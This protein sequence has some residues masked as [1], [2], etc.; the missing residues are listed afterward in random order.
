MKYSTRIKSSVLKKILPPENRSVPS[1][2]K[3]MGI[4]DQTIYNWKK[5]AANG[6]LELDAE[7]I[8][9][10]SLSSIEKFILL[11]E[12]KSKT[13]EIAGVWLREKGL[14]SEHLNLWEQELQDMLKSKDSKYKEEN[15]RLK[16][17]NRA[18]AKEL[19]RKE[20]ALAEV[21][22][23]LTLKKKAQEIWGDREAE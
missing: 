11:L 14:H 4:S 19:L 2:A 8:S 7:T 9:P 20:R 1:V 10:V 21:A 17:E 12:G 13:E 5:M 16:N 22:A 15:I 3:E 23:L 18:L 6:I